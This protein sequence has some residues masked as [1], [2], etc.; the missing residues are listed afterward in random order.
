MAPVYAQQGR[1]QPSVYYLSFFAEFVPLHPE[2]LDVGG[3]A[4]R[5]EGH[6]TAV[7]GK[8]DILD[9]EGLLP[10]FGLAELGLGLIQQVQI[11]VKQIN[12]ALEVASHDKSVLLLVPVHSPDLLLHF[13]KAELLVGGRVPQPQR[14]VVAASHEPE[15]VLRPRLRPE[16]AFA[17]RGDQGFR[18]GRF[19]AERNFVDG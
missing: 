6:P 4:V 8:L 19:L 10:G 9:P 18:F 13:E 2:N 12:L 15:L 11:R 17:V 3:A 5:A 7:G 14:P 16:L 1:G